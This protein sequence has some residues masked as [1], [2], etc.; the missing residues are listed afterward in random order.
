MTDRLASYLG[1]YQIQ[2]NDAVGILLEKCYEYIVACVAIL[3]AGGAYLHL[4]LAY[5]NNFLQQIFTDAAPN[6]VITKE[7][8]RDRM[9]GHHVPALYLD[10]TDWQA[11][12]TTTKKAVVANRSTAIIGY[13]S[14]TTGKPKGIAVSHR[15][16]LYA[17]AK[18]WEEVQHI[19]EKGRFAYTTFIAWDALSPLVMGHTGYI[20]ADE[21]S[22]DPQRL[23][24]FIAQ[25][26]INH[27]FLTPSLLATI[28]HTV[29]AETIRT[30]L[31]CLNIAWVGGEVM[32]QPLVD[33]AFARLPHLCLINNYGPAECFVITQGRLRAHDAATPSICS[34][35]HVLEGMEVMIVDDAMQPVARGEVGELYATGPC[36]ADG[37]VNNRT[38]TKAKFIPIHGKIFYKTEDAAKVLEDGRLVI[39]GRRD[40]TVKIRSYNVNL[41]AIEE[42]L[43]EHPHIA[44]SVVVAHGDEGEDKY[45]VA[46]LIRNSDSSWAIDAQTFRCPEISAYLQTH[47]PFYMVPRL[48]MELPMLPL[49]PISQKLDKS[50]LPRPLFP[51]L[52]H[53]QEQVAEPIRIAETPIAQQEQT[54][55][56]LLEETLPQ[57]RLRL[58]D[59]FFEVGLHSLLAAQ[60]AM[61]VKAVFGRDLS[62]TQIYEHCTA[63]DLVAYLN[64][65]AGTAETHE[66]ITAWQRDAVLASHIEPAAQATLFSAESRAILLTG[67][68]GFLGIFLL[69]EIL[70]AAPNST[71]YCL[72][73]SADRMEALVEKLKRY[74]L[75]HATFDSRIEPLIGDLEKPDFGWSQQTFARYATT[76]QAIFHAGAWV[77]MVYP[78]QRL[79]AANVTGTGELLRFAVHGVNKPLHHISTLG[80]FPSGN[81]AQYRENDQIDGVIEELTTGYAQS[82]WVAEKLVWQAITRDIPAQIYRIGNIGPD[83]RTA[84][85]NA[86]D[87]VM[88]FLESCKRLRIA[89][90]RDEWRFE[91]TP[92]DFVAKAIVQIA[93]CEQ[94]LSPVYHI[95]S[96][97]LVAANNV[98]AEMRRQGTI[99]QMVDFEQWRQ[100]LHQFTQQQSDTHYDLLAQSLAIEE[101]FLLEEEP[102][103]TSHFVEEMQRCQLLLPQV[104]ERYFAG[105][106]VPSASPYRSERVGELPEPVAGNRAPKA[107]P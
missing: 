4:E 7:Q 103:E 14:G 36:L 45:L 26:Q 52:A 34:V 91:Y 16:T 74:R 57:H 56:A 80:I 105:A 67:A 84:F 102:F 83:S 43:K 89:P 85:A 15:A 93:L 73:R 68:T 82:K 58:S 47:L 32:T 94:P 55:L 12:D 37:Y 90:R 81:V 97:Q 64:N 77:N 59:N 42:T 107:Q 60:L 87:A 86:K 71:V 76:V 46:Y 35:G 40:A 65:G 33:E 41:A 66:R 27:T 53:K 72:V 61:R 30:K 62:V 104:D 99:D 96:Q 54:M 48:Y 24:T 29:D 6:V 17:Y 78:Y 39:L 25:H 8:Y 19:H 95:A 1:R 10:A 63:R 11:V 92:V 9:K 23:L 31:R 21:V 5:P 44:D 69:A 101:E 22:F 2:E 49:H 28:L 70:H 79:K 3:K 50:R 88:L 51:R 106:M 98:F 100:H 20:V 18:F 13:S 38:L 75:W